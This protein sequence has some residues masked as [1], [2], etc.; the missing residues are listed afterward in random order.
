MG[1]TTSK[2]QV[3]GRL[4]RHLGPET[5]ADNELWRRLTAELA[6]VCD[7]PEYERVMSV[8]DGEQDGWGW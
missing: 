7:K 2:W 5:E 3:I 6:A 8:R 1:Y 4:D